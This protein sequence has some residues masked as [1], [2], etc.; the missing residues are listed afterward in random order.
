MAA[1][2]NRTI[3]FNKIENKNIFTP[4]YK[5]FVDNNI[6]EFSK[7]NIAVIYGPNGTGKTSLIRSIQGEK[8]TSIMVKNMRMARSSL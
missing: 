6:I 7:Q 3:T 2:D 5:N 8:D 4:D 1:P